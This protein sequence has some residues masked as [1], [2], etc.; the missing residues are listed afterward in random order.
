MASQYIL[1]N[2]QLYKRLF[3]LSLLKYLRPID[4]DYAL[5]EVHKGIC[6]NYLGDKSLAYIVL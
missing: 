5:Q 4:A 2:G 6:E 3:S 1:L